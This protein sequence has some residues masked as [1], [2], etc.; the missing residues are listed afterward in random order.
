LYLLG[1]ALALVGA[2]LIVFKVKS[3]R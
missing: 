2:A 3:V 1:G